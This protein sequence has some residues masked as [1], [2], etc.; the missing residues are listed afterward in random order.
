[1]SRIRQMASGVPKLYRALYDYDSNNE[2]DLRFRANDIIAV[3]DTGESK[4]SWWAGEC[5]GRSGLFP[6][7]FVTELKSV[8]KTFTAVSRVPSLRRCIQR[9]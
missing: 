3:S 5:H 9:R 7:T 2:G 4:D 8:T 6:G 1:M